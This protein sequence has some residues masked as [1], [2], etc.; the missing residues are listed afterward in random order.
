MMKTLKRKRLGVFSMFG[1]I[2]DRNEREGESAKHTK[3][4]RSAL[5]SIEQIL[6]ITKFGTNWDERPQ[7]AATLRFVEQRLW[8]NMAHSSAA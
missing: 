6:E 8:Y 4:R 2:A 3:Q 7:T 5:T 1:C